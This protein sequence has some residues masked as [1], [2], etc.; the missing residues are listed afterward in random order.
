MTKMRT[1]VLSLWR[2]SHCLHAVLQGKHRES[3]TLLEQVQSL[4]RESSNT[5]M[6]G[7]VYK[8]LGHAYIKLSAVT[9]AEQ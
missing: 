4:A 8:W 3:I 1:S 2:L 7:E 6:E 5:G 9:Q